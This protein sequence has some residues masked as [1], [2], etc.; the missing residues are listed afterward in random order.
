M[1]LMMGCVV[2]LCQLPCKSSGSAT[3]ATGLVKDCIDILIKASIANL[4]LSEACFPSLFHVSPLLKKSTFNKDDMKNY[5]S[6]SNL[7]FFSK[8]VEKVVVSR[9]NSQLIVHIYQ[10]IISL[11]IGT[12]TQ[13]KVP[14]LKSRTIFCNQ[15]IMVKSQH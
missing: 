4:S 9:L 7:S 11:H 13:L 12:F 3:I 8:V 15:W 14:F 2:L 1:P 6:V 5:Q 10:I